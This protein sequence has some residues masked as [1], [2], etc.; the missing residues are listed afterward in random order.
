MVK[1][2]NMFYPIL[3]QIFVFAF[4]RFWSVRKYI[5][6]LMHTKQMM[7]L[8]RNAHSAPGPAAPAA[9]SAVQTSSTPVTAAAKHWRAYSAAVSTCREQRETI[10][11]ENCI[12]FDTEGWLG[13]DQICIKS[14][15]YKSAGQSK[16]TLHKV[17]RLSSLKNCVEE[18]TG[19]MTIVDSRPYSPYYD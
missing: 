12:A 11:K 17:I 4:H 8:G 3:K 2:S 13:N 5:I 10:Y 6:A 14:Y 15:G 7:S 9:I 1:V 19:F 18:Q 16:R